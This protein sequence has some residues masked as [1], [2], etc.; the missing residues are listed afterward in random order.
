MVN[1]VDMLNR[2]RLARCRG[3]WESRWL[4]EDFDGLFM[5][6]SLAL[7]SCAPEAPARVEGGE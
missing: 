7:L 2:S 4:R 3:G 1:A 5:G 6:R